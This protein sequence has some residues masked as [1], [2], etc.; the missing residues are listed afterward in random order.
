MQ[1]PADMPSFL[2]PNQSWAE[3]KIHTF[4]YGCDVPLT[5]TVDR[6][7][8]NPQTPQRKSKMFLMLS[9]F[10]PELVNY[11]KL[12]KGDKEGKTIVELFI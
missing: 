10:Q 5:T 11:F 8:G 3:G 2:S 6:N 7:S 4:P 1:V 9:V 12:Y